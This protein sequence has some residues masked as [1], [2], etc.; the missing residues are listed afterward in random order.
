VEEDLRTKLA[1]WQ[2]AGAMQTS[3]QQ[4]D[5]INGL[6][7]S[8]DMD[9]QVVRMMWLSVARGA[10]PQGGPM[11][12]YVELAMKHHGVKVEVVDLG[13][14]SAE[15]TNSCM[16][17]TCAAS[18]ADRRLQGYDDCWGLGLVHDQ[19][20]QACEWDQTTSTDELL[21]EHQRSPKNGRLGRMADALRHAAC[22][23]LAADEEFYTPFFNPRAVDMESPMEAYRRWVEEMRGDEEGDELVILALARICGIAVQSV[24]QSGYHVPLMDPTSSASTGCLMYWGNDDRHWVWLRQKD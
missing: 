19:L 11:D 22:E 1:E 2:L 5:V 15:H 20:E 17:L 18:I 8:A 23:V 13:Q 14:Y 7:Q 12:V 4:S 9:P 16:F 21:V 10:R 3:V 6:S 24:Q